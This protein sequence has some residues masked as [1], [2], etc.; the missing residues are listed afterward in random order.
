MSMLCDIVVLHSEHDIFLIA[1]LY[2]HA[3]IKTLF[4][5][6]NDKFDTIKNVMTKHD[7]QNEQQRRLCLDILFQSF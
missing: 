7:Q 3:I 5:N 6:S 4:I 1:N 2:I